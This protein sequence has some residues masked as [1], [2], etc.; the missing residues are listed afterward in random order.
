MV[1][2]LNAMPQGGGHGGT[3][4]T[5]GGKGGKGGCKGNGGNGG[6]GV[7]GQGGD[8]GDG[9]VGQDC[10]AMRQLDLEDTKLTLEQQS[11]QA[12]LDFKNNVLGSQNIDGNKIELFKMIFA[13]EGH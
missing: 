9:G 3:G 1:M 13:S 11:H 5:A 12:D 4:F 2:G 10:L 8:G 6:V 7:F